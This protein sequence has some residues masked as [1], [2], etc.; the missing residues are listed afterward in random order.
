M[1]P[2]SAFIL[3]VDAS[4]IKDDAKDDWA[5]DGAEYSEDDRL[6]SKSQSSL[7]IC[8]TPTC[9]NKEKKVVFVAELITMEP[10]LS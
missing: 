1:S 3:P 4:R 8:N 5:R 9:R 7:L 10:L 2:F 6:H